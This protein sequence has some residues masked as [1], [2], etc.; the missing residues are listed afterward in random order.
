[1]FSVCFSLFF[2]TLTLRHRGLLIYLYFSYSVFQLKLICFCM[3]FI[4]FR[5]IKGSWAGGS[6]AREMMYPVTIYM[7]VVFFFFPSSLRNSWRARWPTTPISSEVTKYMSYLQS[8]D[9]LPWFRRLPSALPVFV[10]V[11]LLRCVCVI[12]FFTDV[13]EMLVWFE[14]IT[15]WV[16]W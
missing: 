3:F 1:M 7:I 12:R 15:R 9:V 14:Q 6:L 10:F 13:I 16:L 11:V 2:L 4:G 5:A 8:F